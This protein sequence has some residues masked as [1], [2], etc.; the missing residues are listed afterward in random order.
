M[1]LF[2]SP[3]L[4]LVTA[5]Q[6]AT[7]P[8]HL[9]PNFTV[10]CIASPPLVQRPMMA[11]FDDRGRLYVTE[12][13]GLNLDFNK[14]RENPPNS[15]CRLED[16]DGDGKFDKRTIFADRMTF[17]SGALWHN[18]A[19]FVASAPSLWKLED[20][21]DDGVCDKRTEIVTGFGSIGNGADL[22]GPFLGPDGWLYFSDGRNGHSVTLHDGAL[23]KGKAAGVYRCKTDGAGLEVVF[24]GGMDNPVEAVFTPEGEMLV[25]CNLVTARPQRIDG[26]L[27]GIEGGVYPHDSC[28]N[29]YKSTGDLLQPVSNL[30]WVAISGLMRY[31]SNTPDDPL[32]SNLFSAQFNPH[33]VQRHKV[34]RDGAGFRIASEDFL[35]CTSSD[36]HPTDVLQDADGSLLVIDTG[37]WFRIGC[38]ASQIE[39]PNVLGAIYRIRNSNA[40]HQDDPR[41]LKLTWRDASA[42]D[43]IDRLKDPR[44]AVANHAADLLAATSDCAQE[45]E[46]LAIHEPAP[47]AIT[48]IW[49][50]SRRNTPAAQASIRRALANPKSSARRTAIKSAGLS[51]DPNAVP[52]L[53]KLLPSA[54]LAEA[55]ET[56]TALGRIRDNSATAPLL[57]QLNRATDRF[58]E[59]A[60][61]YALICIADRPATAAALA[62]PS[63][64]VRRGAMIALDQMKDGNLTADEIV[65]MLASDSAAVRQ[66]AM[67]IVTTHPQWAA[68]V[69]EQ[70]RAALAKPELDSMEQHQLQEIIIA[71]AKDPGIQTLVSNALNHAASTGKQA[72]LFSAIAQSSLDKFPPAWKIAV[73]NALSSTADE[74]VISEAI[75][76]IRMHA[77][78]AFDDHLI[79]ISRNPKF[80]DPLRVAA[81]T[82]AGPRMKPDPDSFALLLFQ[83]ETTR[84]PLTRLAAARCLA[85]ISL[86]DAQLTQLASAA[87]PTAGPLETSQLLAAFEKSK[88]E[89]VGM[90]LVTALEK[91]N[92]AKALSSAA[93]RN[94]IKNFP[95]TV[96]QAAEPLLQRADSSAAQ[97]K[98]RLRDLQPLLSGGDP[99]RGQSVFFGKKASC[100]TCHAIGG[101][102]AQIGPDLSK[103]GSIRAGADLLESIVFPSATIA[104][105]FESFIV[106]TKDNKTYAGTLA[107]ESSET[108]RLKTPADTTIPR[109]QIKTF[110]PDRLSI[111]P[112][113]LDTQLTRTE[114]NDLL[115]FLQACK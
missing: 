12:S 10:E 15:I 77:L 27:F 36:F 101:I 105:G 14:L 41:G 108:L 2:T 91:S 45:L 90:T 103:I 51:R 46:N 43:L 102:G 47:L 104:R 100:T 21:N 9:P 23:W 48:A 16:S 42:N 38:P 72:F 7:P 33:R 55:Q 3:L 54:D 81:L 114:L 53:L 92:S 113:G 68:Q 59:H 80:T 25:S 61:I 74:T 60:I 89:S 35:T 62:D 88:N 93:L 94:T 8:L 18:G 86:T 5:A 98:S 49:T 34:D 99:S 112:Q 71:F 95:P 64:T 85:N 40:P 39:K 65:P 109:S 50:L 84:P 106:E 97:Q 56:A 31:H 96:L 1:R 69:V 115:A 29:E 24:G 63:P 6:A 82:A 17:P 37:G 111:M 32:D 30:G 28:F 22:H 20:T 67:T 13:A 76:V 87:L 26:I 79:A 52:S 57:A 83:L 11:A 107:S 110:R 78:T 73:A 70:L 75:E 4:F 19:L 66:E 44:P 58:H